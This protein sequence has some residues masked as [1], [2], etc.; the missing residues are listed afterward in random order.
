MQ[1]PEKMLLEVD[2]SLPWHLRSQIMKSFDRGL[3]V[4]SK[5]S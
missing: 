3:Q 5:L 1:S 2:C 4:P